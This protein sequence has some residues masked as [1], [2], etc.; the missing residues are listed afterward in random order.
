MEKRLTKR[1][2]LYGEQTGLH[3]MGTYMKRAYTKT[4]TET[5]NTQT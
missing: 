5:G 1:G 2:D 4:Y 3:I